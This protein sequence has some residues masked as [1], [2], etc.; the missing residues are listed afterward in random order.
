MFGFFRRFADKMLAE[1]K[2]YID[3]TPVDQMR[4]ERGK[5]IESK[6]RANSIAENQRLWGEMQKGSK[7]GLECVMRAKISMTHKNK[8]MRDP[9]LYRCNV[10]TPHHRT[11]TK[12]KVYPTYD[13]ACPIVD[14]IEGVTHALR[15]TEYHDRNDQF[16]WV[17][18]ALGIR[19]PMIEDYSRL[20]AL[21]ETGNFHFL[22]HVFW[23]H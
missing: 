12:W 18:D 2:A 7:E 9:A 4:E 23:D 20:G 13:F 11:G 3:K 22:T 19:K 16:Y 5:G 21:F 1:G 6:Y 17:I 10:E 8:C 14:S 15:T